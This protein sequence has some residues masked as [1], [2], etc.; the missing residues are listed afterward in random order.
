MIIFRQKLFSQSPRDRFLNGSKLFSIELLKIFIMHSSTGSSGHWIDEILGAYNKNTEVYDKTDLLG[1]IETKRKGKL[2]NYLS[3]YP[4]PRDF[5][6][7]IWN[8]IYN[9]KNRGEFKYHQHINKNPSEEDIETN[10]HLFKYVLLCMCGQMNPDKET[11]WAD[12]K[13]VCTLVP[14][15]KVSSEFIN[16]PGIELERILSKIDY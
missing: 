15:F 8:V 4:T 13:E 1:W 2:N 10:L 12:Y 14:T 3:S 9:Q 6:L 11:P 7:M 5:F 16:N